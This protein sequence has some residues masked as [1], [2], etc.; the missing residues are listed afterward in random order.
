[1]S[2]LQMPLQRIQ[3]KLPLLVFLLCLSQPILDA[4]GYWQQTLGMGNAVTM[5][6]RMVLLAGSVM[7]GFLL[8]E[9]KRVYMIAAAV[10][11]VLTVGHIYA[12]MQNPNGYVAPLTDIINLIRIYFLPLMTI[13]LVTFLRSNRK[14]LPALIH[15]LVMDISIIALIQLVSTLTGTDPH[16]YP[17]D[18]VGVLGWFLWTNSQSA[19]LAMLAPISICWAL[20]HWEKRLLPVFAVTVVSE[21]MLYLLAPRLAFASMAAA[22]FCTALCLL[23]I[24]PAR[25]RHVLIVALVTAAFVA[26]MPL[27]PMY[28]RVHYNTIRE[29]QAEEKIKEMNIQIQVVT[30]P[31][32]EAPSGETGPS[33]AAPSAPEPKV[34][35]DEQNADKLESLYSSLNSIWS[36]VDRFGRDRVFEVYDYTL[37]PTILGNVR[38]MKLHFCELLM[39]ESGL[40]SHLFGLNLAE[41]MHKRIE[42]DKVYIDNYDVE[43]DLHGVYFLTGYVGLGMMVLF[44]L[45]FGLRVLI[46]VFRDRKRYFTLPVC[47]FSVS[48]GLGIIH[49]IFTASVLRR[50]NASIYLAVVLAI[51]WYLT[52]R[53]SASEASNES[54]NL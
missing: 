2:K 21:A 26:A 49:A 23:L 43:N 46:A 27:S 33:E 51:L 40:S 8:S 35:L 36:M 42:K 28:K 13:C 25:W 3:D 10:L 53:P 44:L 11:A 5:A 18:G 1:M 4:A 38:V 52:Q 20:L 45:C 48:Y 12:C 24:K 54:E 9:R 16:T 30:E 41:M 22:G 31:L 6:I 39:S 50:N 17:D 37:D 7:F 34:I 14:V 15:G 29:E 47:A 32:T 19:I